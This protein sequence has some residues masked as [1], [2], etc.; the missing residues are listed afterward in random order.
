MKSQ[1][2]NPESKVFHHLMFRLRS[3]V[4]TCSVI[5]P[6]FFIILSLVLKTGA[7]KSNPVLVLSCLGTD[8]ARL[9]SV[10]HCLIV[11]YP[12]HVYNHLE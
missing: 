2:N 4:N 1:F 6:P 7:P 10:W 9:K 12:C 5:F 8:F 3:H 11:S